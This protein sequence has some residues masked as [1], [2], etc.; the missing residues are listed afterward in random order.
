MSASLLD[1]L[2]AEVPDAP[3]LEGADGLHVLALEEDSGARHLGQRPALQQGC[4]HVEGLCLAVALHA[5]TATPKAAGGQD[6]HRPEQPLG[7]PLPA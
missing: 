7:S 4:G 6:T 3:D 1:H 2:L 5:V